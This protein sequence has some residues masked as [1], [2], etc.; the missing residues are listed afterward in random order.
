MT[1]V[2]KDDGTFRERYVLSRFLTVASDIVNNW[3][4]ERDLSSI[5]AKIFAVEPT[6]TLALWT[7][8]YQ[9]AK[10]IKDIICFSNDTSKTFYIPARDFQS[11][12]KTDLNR[13]KNK[14]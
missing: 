2:I 11:I 7:S 9:W 6:I 10:S 13:Y 4:N 14:K 1:K 12:T 3:S 8:S 5:N